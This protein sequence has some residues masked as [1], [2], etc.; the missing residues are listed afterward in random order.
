MSGRKTGFL[1]AVMMALMLMGGCDT[2]EEMKAKNWYNEMTKEKTFTDNTADGYGNYT[3]GPNW[4]T[5]PTDRTTYGM[6]TDTKENTLG[7]DIRNAWDTVKNDVK[8]MG[9][10]K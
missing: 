6:R 9:N 2:A 5:D 8:D 1:A 3:G 10:M 7:Q 4:G